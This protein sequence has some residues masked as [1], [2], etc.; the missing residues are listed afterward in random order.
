MKQLTIA[1]LLALAAFSAA[2]V[3]CWLSTTNPEWCAVQVF[4]RPLTKS[5]RG[6]TIG[7][8][9]FPPLGDGRR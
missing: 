2:G 4:P 7:A 3:A 8:S 9:G 1:L 5:V 6:S